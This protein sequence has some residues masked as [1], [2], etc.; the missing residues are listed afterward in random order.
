MG[1]GLIQECSEDIEGRAPLTT[2]HPRLPLG[3]RAS[4]EL[5]ERVMCGTWDPA[6][7]EADRQSRDA[8]AARG[9]RQALQK[10]RGSVSRVL[11]GEK[12]GAAAGTE[13]RGWYREP[14][15]LCVASGLTPASA[16]AGYR[17]IFCWPWEGMDRGAGRR[18]RGVPERMGSRTRGL[19]CEGL[20]R[21]D[22]R[23]R[24][25]AGQEDF[26]KTIRKAVEPHSFSPPTLALQRRI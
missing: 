20:R 3:Y 14:H 15:E 24:N 21:M 25:R 6:R 5:I 11:T 13:H 7:H 26:V 19:R 8:L 22:C 18:S 2:R 16:L 9:Y 12:P 17:R 10:V 1:A 23:A 4:P